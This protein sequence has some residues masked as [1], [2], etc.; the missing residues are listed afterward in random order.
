MKLLYGAD[1][2]ADWWDFEFEIGRAPRD[3][4]Y[5]AVWRALFKS[6]VPIDRGLA[7]AYRYLI[8][9][10]ASVSQGAAQRDQ[11]DVSAMGFQTA[12]S[13]VK[14]GATPDE[15]RALLRSYVD[16][17]PPSVALAIA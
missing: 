6:F 7:P 12:S 11:G 8:R 1:R 3:S 15:L 10:R 14:L 2:C 13:F 4:E 5:C 9:N 16:D 17:V